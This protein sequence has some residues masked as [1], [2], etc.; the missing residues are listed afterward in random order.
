MV[1]LFQCIVFRNESSLLIFTYLLDIF[2][3][4]L[5][6]FQYQYIQ[7]ILL[8]DI[9]YLY[10]RGNFT[11]AI[12]SSNSDCDRRSKSYIFSICTMYKMKYKP[13][14]VIYKKSVSVPSYLFSNLTDFSIDHSFH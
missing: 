12:L 7:G 10:F 1:E 4:L 3:F 5:Y 13:F 14:T 6:P 9:F 11:F 2:Y 8:V